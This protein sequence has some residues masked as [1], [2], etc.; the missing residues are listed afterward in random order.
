MAKFLESLVDLV[1]EFTR[2]KLEAHFPFPATAEKWSQSGRAN[3]SEATERLRERLVSPG[4][5]TFEQD[6]KTLQTAAYGEVRSMTRKR[7][8]RLLELVAEIDE[9]GIRN[10]IRD[11]VGAPQRKEMLTEIREGHDPDWTDPPDP[12]EL[13]QLLRDPAKP[14][15]G[16]WA[17][18]IPAVRENKK[19][20]HALDGFFEWGK[21]QGHPEYVLYNGWLG[22]ILGPLL[23]WRRTRGLM[24]AWHEL[25]TS[26]RTQ[27]IEAGITRAKLMLGTVPITKRAERMDPYVTPALEAEVREIEATPDIIR[28]LEEDQARWDTC[29]AASAELDRRGDGG[30]T[31]TELLGS[32]TDAP[33][34]EV[35][36]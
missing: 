33:Q 21:R 10:E 36:P 7:F 13:A 35:E 29:K 18:T 25:K 8:N 15:V 11:L 22:R 24:P 12:M 32:Q 16:R 19:I 4:S 17:E 1:G 9:D 27:F 30:M 26:E 34:E 2:K 3:V 6:R 14:I 23:D 5:Y 28:L 20:A 31:W